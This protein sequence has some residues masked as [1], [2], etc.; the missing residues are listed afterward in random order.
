M[1]A[2]RSRLRVGRGSRFVDVV[3]LLNSR[4]EAPTPQL[5][6]PIDLAR[7]L[8]LWPLTREAVEVTLET[9]GGPLKAW[10]YPRA[11]VVKVITEDVKSREVL[12]DL[13]VSLLANEP[14][15]SDMLAKELG[16]A[17]ESFGKGLWRFRWEPKEKLRE[18]AK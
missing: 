3:A 17:V 12:V 9:A 18:S 4:Y 15:I 10:F 6:I 7:K 16:I 14:L 5:L 8:N 1:L 2:I 13:I 11:A